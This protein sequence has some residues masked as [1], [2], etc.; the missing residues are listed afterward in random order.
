MGSLR[1]QLL[2]WLLVPLFA[3]WG[4]D[5]AFTYFDSVEEVNVG[6]DRTLAGSALMMA[7]RVAT[8]DG[9]LTVDIPYAAIQMLESGFRDRIYYRVVDLSDGSLVTGY[10]DLPEPPHA[11]TPEAPLFFNA[12]YKGSSVRFAALLRPVYDPVVKGPALI[13]IGESTAAR[14]AQARRILLETTLKEMASIALVAV[15]LWWGVRR[16]L[17][18]LRRLRDR[19]AARDSA[20]LSP[21][22]QHDVP[23]EVAPLIDAINIQTARQQALNEFQHQFIA[24]ASHQ[25][26]TPLTVLKTQVEL[27]LRQT[28]PEAIRAVLRGMLASTDATARMVRQLL[29]LA[30]SDPAH[31]VSMSAVDLARLAR[32][33]MLEMTQQAISRSIDLGYEGE[34]RAEVVG[35]DLLLH[36]LV[37][38]LLDNALRYLGRP[39]RVTLRVLRGD[40][41][42]LLEVDDDGPGIPPA[43]RLRLTERFYRRADA[44][45]DGSGLGLAIVAG[46]V[47]RHG[48]TLQFDEPPGGRGLLVRVRFGR[49]DAPR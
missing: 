14:E 48:A 43:D 44:K 24:D 28:D 37:I 33:A 4:I 40:G 2:R 16:G 13:Q 18:P 42:T 49:A 23:G 45:G 17:R 3:L 7:E 6:F 39:G 15:L 35:N 20:D 36:E 1:G 25:L 31:A 30:R 5:F 29:A 21:I 22:P 34:D 8:D 46:I 10:E 41:A 38:N 11:P 27:A 19:V 26:K 12:S 32:E 9:R 47:A